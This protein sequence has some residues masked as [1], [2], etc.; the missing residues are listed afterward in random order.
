MVSHDEQFRLFVEE[1]QKLR[2]LNTKPEVIKSEFIEPR[3]NSS[4]NAPKSSLEPYRSFMRSYVESINSS[5]FKVT[6]GGVRI[7]SAKYSRLAQINLKTRI[8]TFSRFA[9]ENVPERARRYLVLHELAHVLEASHNRDYWNYVKIFEPEYK[10]IGKDLDNIFK[11]N[12]RRHERQ[13]KQNLDGNT[14]PPAPFSTQALKQANLIWTPEFGNGYEA[15]DA[16]YPDNREEEED[17]EGNTI[18]TSFDPDFY[19]DDSLEDSFFGVIT[20]GD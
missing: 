6:I 8:I 13:T 20:G 15:I 18:E 14:L 5:T 16:S 19:F 2:Q 7:G 9:V 17:D 11:E 10:R 1:K 4:G 12:V 3:Q